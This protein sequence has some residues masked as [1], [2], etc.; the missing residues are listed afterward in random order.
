MDLVEKLKKLNIF[1][2]GAGALGC[3]IMKLLALMGVSTAKNSNIILTDNDSIEISKLNRQFLFKNRHIG[4]NKSLICC[5]EIK[6]INPKIN[7]IAL[8]KLVNHNSEDIFNNFFGQILI[9]LF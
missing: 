1:I 7:C 8:D 5:E 6:K 2:I 9:L 3:E 4:K